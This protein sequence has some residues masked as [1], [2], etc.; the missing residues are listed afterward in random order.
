MVRSFIS[1]ERAN[2]ALTADG[3]VVVWGEA[4]YGG[5][6]RKVQH[7]LVDVQSINSNNKAFAATKIDGSIVAWGDA[8]AQTKL[9]GVAKFVIKNGKGSATAAVK[10]DGSVVAWGRDNEGGDCSKA[11]KQLAADVQHIS[12]TGSAFAALK[13]DGTVVAWGAGPKREWFSRDCSGDCSAVQMQLVDVQ[14]IYSTRFA[15]AAL[16]AGGS[17]VA[18]GSESYGGDCSEVQGQLVDVHT[19][20]TSCSRTWLKPTYM[21]VPAD[22]HATTLPSAF[23]AATA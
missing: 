15:F 22:P 12:A 9:D 10:T 1:N 19:S 16:K 6:C 17:V 4:S 2:A 7:Q 11:Q 21:P 18:W 20:T 13:N 23:S 5:D 8:Q 3:N 14:H